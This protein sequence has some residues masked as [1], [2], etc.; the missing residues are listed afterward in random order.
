MAYGQNFMD[1][2]WH[3]CLII[4]F[5]LLKSHIFHNTP[6]SVRS[7][8]LPKPHLPTLYNVYRPPPAEVGQPLD[9]SPFK[10]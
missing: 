2:S 9:N 5:S 7:P 4:S 1:K 6:A 3:H 8:L 10:S